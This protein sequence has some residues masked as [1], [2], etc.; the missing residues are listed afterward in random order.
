MQ[1]KRLAA[2]DYLTPYDQGE[3]EVD[4]LAATRNNNCFIMGSQ[5]SLINGFRGCRDY[6]P[7]IIPRFIRVDESSD[8]LQQ[9]RFQSTVFRYQAFDKELYNG[10]MLF[11]AF[12]ST[13]PKAQR[14]HGLEVIT[15]DAQGRALQ[16]HRYPLSLE[17]LKRA[18]PAIWPDSRF[19]REQEFAF[20]DLEI[21]NVNANLDC[22]LTI[23]AEQQYINPDYNIVRRVAGD[24]LILRVQDGN[25]LEVQRIPKYAEQLIDNTANYVQSAAFSWSGS[26][27]LFVNDHYQNHLQQEDAKLQPLEEPRD[28]LTLVLLLQSDGKLRYGVLRDLLQRP[29]LS[30]FPTAW[31]KLLRDEKLLVMS[32]EDNAQ[33]STEVLVDFNTLPEKLR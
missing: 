18:V 23:V 20:R 19:L 7:L 6:G 21:I 13:N 3:F 9:L 33:P 5:A 2:K 1:G 28:A 32:V 30:F 14:S 12:Y 31:I 11:A 27:A 8:R 26:T 4:V 17:R 29:A 24:I 15:I 10:S 16:Y 22:S 25:L